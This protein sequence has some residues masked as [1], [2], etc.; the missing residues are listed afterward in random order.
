MKII[1]IFAL[2]VVFVTLNLCRGD[3]A[4]AADPAPTPL[5][6]APPSQDNRPTYT[7]DLIELI[8]SGEP[9]K[10][11]AVT[12]AMNDID[13]GKCAMSMRRAHAPGTFQCTLM[14]DWSKGQKIEAELE[15][16]GSAQFKVYEKNGMSIT[17]D[18]LV[19]RIYVLVKAP[20]EMEAGRLVSYQ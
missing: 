2:V 11:K 14:A 6:A 10:G 17:V 3:R 8:P 13:V 5:Q 4:A 15:S 16:T 20:D 18:F 12:V 1:K 19:D 9:S 7:A